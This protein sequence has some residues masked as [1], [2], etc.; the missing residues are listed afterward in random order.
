MQQ[1]K[2]LTTAAWVSVGS[3]TG[4]VQ[5]IKG[6]D[7]GAAPVQVTTSVRIQSLAW[8][9]PRAVGAAIKKCKSDHAHI[10]DFDGFML[11]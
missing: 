11:L 10:S 6:S 2:N 3:I 8:E 5:W 7:V 1:V 4:Q 9:L